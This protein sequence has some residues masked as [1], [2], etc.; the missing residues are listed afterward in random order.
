LIYKAYCA[1]L[2]NIAKHP[3]PPFLPLLGVPL[4]VSFPV[5]EGG[6]PN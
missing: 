4:G 1:S 5:Q 2:L 6:T 3:I